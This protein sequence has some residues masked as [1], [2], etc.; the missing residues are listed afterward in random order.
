MRV[1]GQVI[2]QRRGFV[3]EQRQ[4]VLDT[5]RGD[6]AAQVLKDRAAPEVDIEALAEPRLEARDRILLQRKLSR[7]QQTNGVHLVDGALVFRIEG[8]Q[9]LD[10][11][12]E[13]V[14]AIGQFAAHREQ[15]DQRAAHGEFA[16]L[17]HRVDVAI[18][19]GLEPGAHLLDVE[20][21][22]DVQHQAAAEQES[23]RRQAMQ[24][25]GDRHHQHAMT[26]LRQPV[27][28]GDALG[29]DVLVRREQVVGQGFPVREMQ[30]GQ[31]RGEEAQLLFQP[32]GTLAVGGHAAG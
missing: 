15:V 27:Q 12:V 1:L 23:R 2:E 28:G 6:P 18:A 30:H 11:V 21:L 25:R 9:G 22:A 3:E 16:V 10:F 13:Q 26:Q 31:I 14:D 32:F 17:V 5:G 19:A 4:V 7:R 20:F 24:G 29:N 8:A